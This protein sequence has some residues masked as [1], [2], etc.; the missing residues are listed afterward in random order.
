[1]EDSPALTNLAGQ[2]RR[3][4]NSIFPNQTSVFVK[5]TVHEQLFGGYRMCKNR[6]GID[7]KLVCP[8]INSFAPKEVVKQ[9]DGSYLFTFFQHVSKQHQIIMFITIL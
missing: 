3:A 5:T 2:I 4:F 1:M 7:A 8:M 6:K 9:K